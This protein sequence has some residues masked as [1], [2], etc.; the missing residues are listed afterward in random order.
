MV[1]GGGGSGASIDPRAGGPT[2]LV[3]AD[4]RELQHVAREHQLDAC[5]AAMGVGGGNFS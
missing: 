5:G 1:I 3:P 2:A 4:G